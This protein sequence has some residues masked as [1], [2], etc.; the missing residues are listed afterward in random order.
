[1]D[2][3]Y[4]EKIKSIAYVTTWVLPV[5]VVAYS[6]KSTSDFQAQLQEAE[7]K[8]RICGSK[9]FEK[10]TVRYIAYQ[11]AHAKANKLALTILVLGIIAA[12]FCLVYMVIDITSFKTSWKEFS[13]L[14]KNEWIAFTLALVA[15]LRFVGMTISL[16][17]YVSLNYSERH[18]KN[19][20]AV[21]YYGQAI[22]SIRNL[23]T[24]IHNN[25]Q[26]GIAENPNKNKNY[27]LG[28]WER[29]KLIL[30]K[31]VALDQNLTSMEEAQDKVDKMLYMDQM[32]LIGYIEFNLERD[33]PILKTLITVVLEDAKQAEAT[34]FALDKLASPISFD[35]LPAFQKR[36]RSIYTI[37]LMIFV[38]VALMFFI[39]MRPFTTM[40]LITVSLFSVLI[41]MLVFVKA[42]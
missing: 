29:Y 26:T 4:V 15:S 31:R 35:P 5:I 24:A 20:P 23:L 8:Q 40:P 32:G 18:N 22:Q 16:A 38:T 41:F 11:R 14:V 3:D 17:Y 7:R 30:A 12:I 36:F 33:Y 10:E 19:I 37:L 21:K 27:K 6:Y 42:T 1:M 2:V 39:K 13:A 9:A 28:E 25:I 34:T